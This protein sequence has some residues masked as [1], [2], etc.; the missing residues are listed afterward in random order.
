MTSCFTSLT[1]QNFVNII[2]IRPTILVFSFLNLL[3]NISCL[4]PEE[5]ENIKVNLFYTTV[6]CT[7]L[8]WLK[9]K[10]LLVLRNHDLNFNNVCQLF[11]FYE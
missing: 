5:L 9:L 4:L 11:Y 1:G 10:N 6:K 7:F 3:F 8:K 2:T